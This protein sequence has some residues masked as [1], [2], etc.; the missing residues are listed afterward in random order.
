VGRL[1][2]DQGQIVERRE[3]GLVTAA[4]L[5][6]S[7]RHYPPGALVVVPHGDHHYRLAR[8]FPVVATRD[9][10]GRLSEDDGRESDANVLDRGERRVAVVVL[11]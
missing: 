4:E 3:G 10:G 7:L 2:R 5:I 11:R 6:E 9:K 1:P 8:D